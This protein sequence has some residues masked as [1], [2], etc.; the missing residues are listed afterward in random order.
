MVR[1]RSPDRFRQGA[2]NRRGNL[3]S[4]CLSF[5]FPAPFPA[6]LLAGFFAV[7]Q[8]SPGNNQGPVIPSRSMP[9][10][11]GFAAVGPHSN[12]PLASALHPAGVLL[13]HVLFPGGVPG[14]GRRTRR[15]EA[16]AGSIPMPPYMR[17]CPQTRAG[18]WT[19]LPPARARE[20]PS[21]RP[22]RHD[23][24]PAR[25]WPADQA[26]CGRRRAVFPVNARL[27]S[28]V[29]HRR[30]LW[31]PLLS[32]CRENENPRKGPSGPFRGFP[33]HAG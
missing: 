9:L 26:L 18:L 29:V 22:R 21:Q 20:R 6:P 10:V 3:N 30:V 16:A 28:A 15:A 4:D 12:R 25:P 17:A 2:R 11:I 5:S 13:P 7:F 23:P 32:R 14:I 27:L 8:A 1:T 24:D 19:E 31:T 33:V